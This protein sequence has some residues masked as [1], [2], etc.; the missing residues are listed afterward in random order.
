MKKQFS[1]FFLAGLLLLITCNLY[2]QKDYHLIGEVLLN[3]D[4]F[5]SAIKAFSLSIEKNHKAGESYS[6]RG[7]AHYKQG[8]WELA[9]S[10]LN[11]AIKLLS[12]TNVYWFD[13]M[14]YKTIIF[15]R[16]GKYEQALLWNDSLSLHYP[17]NAKTITNHA[18]IK[19]DMG[20][21]QGAIAELEKA[22]AL[23]PNEDK[24]YS[25]YGLAYSKLGLKEKAIAHF[26]QAIELN[27]KSAINY[28]NRAVAYMKSGEYQQ[29]LEDCNK[30][31]SLDD[32]LTLAYRNRASI[33]SKVG[34]LEKSL[35]DM[36][37]CTNREP[38]NALF[39]F[40]KAQYYVKVNRWEKALE[41]Y[42]T[43]LKLGLG[44]EDAIACAINAGFDCLTLE[45]YEQA[46]EF[47][48]HAIAIDDQ[49]AFAYNNRAFANMKLGKIN[50]AMEDV[51][52][53]LRLMPDNSYAYRN[54][55][56]IWITKGEKGKACD[57][58]HK[59]LQLNHNSNDKDAIQLLNACN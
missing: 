16:Q 58:W 35:S 26:S 53:S 32:R 31:I 34:E 25:L 5:E 24:I 18:N 21:I 38:Q 6:A 29:A 3:Q 1:P 28:V 44:K 36:D 46:I 48:N 42:K 9:L 15:R 49:E 56:L 57:D 20:Q 23:D 37:T 33:W 27:P 52:T 51:E 55:G 2:A 41:S 13:A 11:E 7:F 50:E 45:R 59:A 8:D 12:P 39:H 14:F 10:D 19:L 22:L 4:K 17:D 40:H 47:F 43:A 54:R 30:A